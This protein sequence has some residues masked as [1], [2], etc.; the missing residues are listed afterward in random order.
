MAKKKDRVIA[1]ATLTKFPESDSPYEG[2]WIF[3]M[4]VNW[5]Y[6][7]MGIGE[8]LT[9]MA[10]D[11]AVKHGASE[12]KLLVFEDAKPAN[13]LYR[14]AGFKRIFISALDEQLKEEAKRDSRLR[15]ILAKD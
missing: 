12:I 5:R 1:S 10:A 6:R 7:R 4:K 11:L 8:K 3:G 13:D 15:I 2:W 9:K 14:K